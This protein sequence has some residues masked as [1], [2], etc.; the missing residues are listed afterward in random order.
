MHKPPCLSPFAQG[1][2][3]MRSPLA[4]VG[5]IAPGLALANPSGGVVTAGQAQIGPAAGSTLEIHQGSGAAAIN[6]QQFSIGAEEYVVFHQ[7]S[8]SATVL[9]RVIGGSASEILGHLTANGRVFLLNPAGVVFG[10]G[11]Q[12]DVGGLLASTL[13]IADDDFM[14]GRY[15]FTR[16]PGSSGSLSNAGRIS[17]APGGYVVLAGERVSN[18]GLIEA[19]LGTV[20]LASGAALTLGLDGEGLVSFSVDGAALSAAAGVQNLGQIVADG[21]RVLMSARVAQDLAGSAV[22]NRGTIQARSIAE[23]EGAIVLSAE[24]GYVLQEG[25]LDVSGSSSENAGSVRIVSDRDIVLT[26]DSDITASGASGGDVRVVAQR[27]LTHAKGSQIDVSRIGDG[28]GGFVELSGYRNLTFAEVV[29]VGPAGELLLDPATYTIGTTDGNNSISRATLEA[30]LK[31]TSTGGVFSI[32]VTD[33]AGDDTIVIASSIDGSNPDPAYGGGLRL[34]INNTGNGDNLGSITTT[35][36]T[37]AITVDGVIFM[38]SGTAGGKITTGALTSL[39]SNISLDGVSGIDTQALSAPDGVFLRST[40][41]AVSSGAIDSQSNVDIFAQGGGVVAGA[42][43]VDSNTLAGNSINIQARDGIKTGNLAVRTRATGNDQLLFASVNLFANAFSD[44]NAVPSLVQTGTISLSTDPVSFVGNSAQ[45]FINIQN[46]VNTLPNQT[47]GTTLVGGG[48]IQTGAI[49]SN[50]V[51]SGGNPASTCC[52]TTSSTSFVQIFG[53]GDITLGGISHTTSGASNPTATSFINIFADSGG[54]ISTGALGLGSG[55]DL[56]LT[57]AAGPG[58]TATPPGNITVGALSGTL[59]S[60]FVDATGS[61]SIASS[62]LTAEDIRIHAGQGN[63]LLGGVTA[64]TGGVFLEA[65]AGRVQT[66]AI[67]AT[68]AESYGGGIF[69]SARD[70]ITTGDLKVLVTATGNNQSLFGGIFLTVDPDGDAAAAGGNLVTGNIA[71]TLSPA[72]FSGISSDANVRLA[73]VSFSGTTT[74]VPDG[75]SIQAGN[76][77]ITA[78]GS[79]HVESLCPGC[80]THTSG[81]VS[82]DAADAVSAGTIT[83]NGGGGDTSNTRG[84][85]AISYRGGDVKLSTLSLNNDSS[86]AVAALADPSALSNVGNITLGAI[87]GVDD[88]TA[89]ASGILTIDAGTSTLTLADTG[90]FGDSIRLNAGSMALSGFI[91]ANRGVVITAANTVSVAGGGALLNVNAGGLSIAAG[92]VDIGQSNLFVGAESMALGTDST[93]IGSLPTD[94]RPLTAGP[95]AAFAAA[96]GVTIGNIDIGGGYLFVRAPSFASGTINGGGS[97]PSGTG[98]VPAQAKV[99]A[100]L[101]FNV[102]PFGDTSNLD[103]TGI[104]N[105]PAV[106]SATSTFAFGGSGYSGDIVA[107]GPVDLSATGGNVVLATSGAIPAKDSITTSGQVFVVGGAPPPPPPPPPAPLPPDDPTVVE[108]GSVQS[109]VT[110]IQPVQEQQTLDQQQN[111]FTTLQIADSEVVDET[112]DAPQEETQCR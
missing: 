98:T 79:A 24:G 37:N 112:S 95:N 93:L 2:R 61:V 50:I 30:Q 67:S 27:D 18:S 36:D 107:S 70:G 71:V 101:F 15:V 69:V 92:L 58:T 102:R 14:S 44:P 32:S 49:T 21:G 86:V 25:S 75:G 76:I 8:A 22:N 5:L 17:A 77:L 42:I 57:S 47:G 87:S 66:G 7:P 104:A 83:L 63:L 52:I 91:G 43:T 4:V 89:S 59:G 11:A 51:A 53:S 55:T 39:E 40:A 26:G 106:K 78:N 46:H 3:R 62:A 72:S 88:F 73:N 108:T 31:T 68:G 111:T 48:G 64:G 94:L 45:G 85:D 110:D 20:A 103:I 100:P 81:F 10:K 9:N 65:D 1:L 90:L 56:N 19:Q 84:V 99:T 29:K 41:G 109:A 13:D 38:N 96:G 23:H 28:A 16:T 12:V 34:F 33:T 6:W 60:F 82:L 80:T 54:S 97:P 35:S 105:L 74:P